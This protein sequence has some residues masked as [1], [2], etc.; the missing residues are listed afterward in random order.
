MAYELRTFAIDPAG[1]VLIA[2]STT[3]MLVDEQGVIS[4]VSAGLSVYRIGADGKLTSVSK[5]GRGYQ[6]RR[7]VLVRAADDGLSGRSASQSVLA[8]TSA[9][10]CAAGV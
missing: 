7:A 5:H 1:Q 3:P 4:T 6:R 8:T 10:R 2:A 9:A